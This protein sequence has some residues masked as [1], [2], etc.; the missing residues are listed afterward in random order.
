MS[1]Q[2]L[3]TALHAIAPWVLLPA[4][5]GAAAAGVM[6]RGRLALV[7]IVIALLA[8]A[9]PIAADVIWMLADPAVD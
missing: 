1:S 9:I 5:M 8:V 6:R 7:L 2:G 3:T 4:A